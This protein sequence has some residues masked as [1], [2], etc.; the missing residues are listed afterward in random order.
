MR[1]LTTAELDSAP[2]EI[3]FLYTCGVMKIPVGT[4]IVNKAMEQHPEYFPDEIENKKKWEMVPKS[5]TDEYF[6]EYHEIWKDHYKDI[7]LSPGIGSPDFLEW[8]KKSV[9]IGPIPEDKMAALNEKHYGVYGIS[10]NYF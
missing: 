1:T 5:A 9:K 4:S 8:Y 7:G 6:K 10:R 2:T 3:Q